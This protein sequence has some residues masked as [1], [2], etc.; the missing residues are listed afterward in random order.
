MA[1]MLRAVVDTNVI[2]AALYSSTGASSELLRLLIAGDWTLVLSHT[3]CA[4]YEEVLTREAATLE[5]T[6]DEVG[7]FLDAL[8]AMAER[9]HLKGAW[10]P[11]LNDPDDE[12]QV[13]LASETGG[14]YIVSHNVRHL[15]PA[16]ELGI[17]VMT[18]K[19]FLNILR[20]QP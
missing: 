9:H 7:R 18:P 12:A 10:I 3:L 11:V 5:I 16:R 1:A 2:Y 20:N 13:H 6:K 19:E 14:D 4:E 15:E 17:A 8:C